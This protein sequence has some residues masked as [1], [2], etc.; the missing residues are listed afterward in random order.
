VIVGVPGGPAVQLDLVDGLTS[1]RSALLVSHQVGFTIGGYGYDATVYDVLEIQFDPCA[2]AQ[3][4]IEVAEPEVNPAGLR[5]RRWAPTLV[6]GAEPTTPTMLTIEAPEGGRVLAMP[7]TY[8]GAP[9]PAEELAAALSFGNG[10][11]GEETITTTVEG[12]PHQATWV[13][14]MVQTRPTD[15]LT[16]AEWI[17][18]LSPSCD[19]ADRCES[20]IGVSSLAPPSGERL[21]VEDLVRSVTVKPSG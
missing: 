10:P 2:A 9:V 5:V 17:L 19:G 12:Q 16:E 20:D 15:A 21:P 7:A 3:P 11:E 6:P 13:D 14:T 1:R 18:Y 4:C 8:A